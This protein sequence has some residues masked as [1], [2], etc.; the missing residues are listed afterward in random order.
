MRNVQ[1]INLFVSHWIEVSI[2][3]LVFGADLKEYIS[4]ILG[5]SGSYNQSTAA[6][7]IDK[8]FVKMGLDIHKY[9][10]GNGKVSRP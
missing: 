6:V 4:G 7:F 8:E 2:E 9:S 1:L 5:D 10:N 3:F